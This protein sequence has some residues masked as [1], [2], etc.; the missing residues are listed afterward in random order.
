MK[1]IKKLST[2]EVHICYDNSKTLCDK[3]IYN[4]NRIGYSDIT[5]ADDI[6]L[7]TCRECKKV[8]AMTEEEFEE[9]SKKYNKIVCRY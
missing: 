6:N 5:E 4:I 3:D 8:Y 2:G 7:I 9:H 1:I